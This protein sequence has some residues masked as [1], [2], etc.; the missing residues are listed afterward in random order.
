MHSNFHI[1]LV[2]A[3]VYQEVRTVDKLVETKVAYSNK[4][5]GQCCLYAIYTVSPTTFTC[6]I[7]HLNLASVPF[8]RCQKHD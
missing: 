3:L 2:I 7:K 6:T 1:E 8:H 4:P 5:S